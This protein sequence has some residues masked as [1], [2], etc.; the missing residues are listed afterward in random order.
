MSRFGGQPR[1]A[2]IIGHFDGEEIETR[3]TARQIIR[4]C[5]SG[6]ERRADARSDNTT[7]LTRRILLSELQKRQS[8]PVKFA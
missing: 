6:R 8:T 3:W 5:S 2:P 4:F 1:V 7:N